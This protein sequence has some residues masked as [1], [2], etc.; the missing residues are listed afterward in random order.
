MYMSRKDELLRVWT[1]HA[2]IGYVPCLF[3]DYNFLRHPKSVNERPEGHDGY[4]WFGVHWTYQPEVN[5]PMVSSGYPH[6]ITDITKW[7]EQVQFPDLKIY[8]W[9]TMAKE[10]T[11]DWDRENK[12]S[13]VMLIN[14]CFER[15]HHLMGFEE[16]LMAMYEEPEAYQAL[17]NRI[18]DFKC[19]LIDIVSKYYK[20]DILMM[21]DDYGAGDRMLMS[22]EIWRQLIKKPLSRLVDAVHRNGVVY[23]HHS[24][25]CIEPI[26]GD[27]VEIGVDAVNSLQRPCNDIE[28]IKKEYGGKIT[29][30]G[31]FSSQ[32]VIENPSST[33]EDIQ[34]DIEFAY[35]TLAPGG[36]YV[37]FPILIDIGGFAPA[38]LKAHKKLARKFTNVEAKI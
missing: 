24:C 27:L 14:G 9:E 31:G 15:S 21:H 30:V 19:E 1:E 5:A 26:I 10:E 3:V 35:K 8:D 12:V 11:K 4:D 18:A 25:G 29:L 13:V 6:V 7:E 17:L 36:G 23:E 37:A 33:P 2:D 34:N 20:P 32:A 38:L 22:P 28:K 16:A